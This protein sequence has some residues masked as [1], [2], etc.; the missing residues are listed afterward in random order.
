MFD[1]MWFSLSAP[2]EE[3]QLL[4][5]VNDAR[6]HPEKYPPQ[7]DATGAVMDACRYRFQTSR[8]L[9]LDA[10]AHCEFLKDQPV[11]WVNADLNMHRGPDGKPTWD[12]GEPMDQDGY[13]SWRA[14]NV[15]VGF[16]TPEEVVRFWMQDDQ[17]WAWKH[18]NAILR[19]LTVEAGVGHYQG[20]PGNHYWTLDM[21]TQ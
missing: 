11:D 6:V 8:A 1:Q 9:V 10:R 18:R 5:L 14:E 7:G 12:P 17:T 20:G 19:S 15:A 2:E 13:K 21:A 4:G 16:A 3:K